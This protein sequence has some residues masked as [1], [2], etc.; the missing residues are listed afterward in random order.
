LTNAAGGVTTLGLAFDARPE[1]TIT[2]V[3]W[4]DSD[5]SACVIDA[6]ALGNLGINEAVYDYYVNSAFQIQGWIGEGL[7]ADLLRIA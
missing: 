5:P 1:R 3:F 2:T 7:L 4:S 6:D